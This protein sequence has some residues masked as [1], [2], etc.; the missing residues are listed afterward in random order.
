MRKTAEAECEQPFDDRQLA[1]YLM[2]PKVTR[3]YYEH[4]KQNGDTAVLP[5]PVFFYGPQPQQ[6]I[7][8][9]IDPGCCSRSAPTATRHRR[10]SSN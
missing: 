3:D 5:T 10:C 7:A 9:E 8:V 1:S 4:L 6:E 2:Y